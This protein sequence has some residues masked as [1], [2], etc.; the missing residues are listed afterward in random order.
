MKQTSITALQMF[1]FM[2]LGFGNG[3]QLTYRTFCRRFDRYPWSLTGH[4][5]RQYRVR[6]FKILRTLTLMD[7]HLSV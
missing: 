6:E 5:L 3:V 7:E 1:F 2:L 4:P